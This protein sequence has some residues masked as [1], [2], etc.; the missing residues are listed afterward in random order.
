MY[1]LTLCDDKGG[2]S[3]KRA[4]AIHISQANDVNGFPTD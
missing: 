3:F 1:Q 2:D 4:Y